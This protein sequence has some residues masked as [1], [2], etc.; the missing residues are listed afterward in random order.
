MDHV[1]DVCWWHLY[2]LPGGPGTGVF[3]LQEERVC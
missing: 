3:T 2:L 1:V